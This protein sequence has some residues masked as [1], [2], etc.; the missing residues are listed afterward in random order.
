MAEN[1]AAGQTSARAVALA[2]ICSSGHRAAILSCSMDTFGTG[3]A[4]S[5]SGRLYWSQ[6]FGCSRTNSC[7]C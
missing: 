5:S 1:V 4:R 3:V 7:S 2:W 6:S